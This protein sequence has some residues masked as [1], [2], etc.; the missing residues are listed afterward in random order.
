MIRGSNSGIGKRNVFAQK[1]PDR[2]IQSPIRW[3]LRFL[4]GV[5]QLGREADHSPAFSDMDKIFFYRAHP[6][7]Y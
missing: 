1:R 3:V 5:K 7:V 6:F 4:A 2:H